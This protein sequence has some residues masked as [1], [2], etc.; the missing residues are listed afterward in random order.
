MD[1]SNSLEK[2]HNITLEVT[3]AIRTA[4]P[5]SE[6]IVHQDPVPKEKLDMLIKLKQ[7]TLS[8]LTDKRI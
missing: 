4:L 3:E 2:A 1:G 5:S 7:K 6:V 8:A